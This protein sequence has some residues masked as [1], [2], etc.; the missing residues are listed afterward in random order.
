M[1]GFV[2]LTP[3][4]PAMAPETAPDAPAPGCSGLLEQPRRTS[5]NG[6]KPFSGLTAARPPAVAHHA[7]TPKRPPADAAA[8]CSR[9]VRRKVAIPSLS[10]TEDDC[11]NDAHEETVVKGREAA[12]SSV[13]QALGP[14]HI[15]VAGFKFYKDYSQAAAEGVS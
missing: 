15:E 10:V 2:P 14:L 9:G 4:L 13:P 7:P 8:P 1:V 6:K 3:T 5:A 12:A 11:R